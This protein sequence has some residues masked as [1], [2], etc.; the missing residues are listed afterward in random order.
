[1]DIMRTIYFSLNTLFDVAQIRTFEDFYSNLDNQIARLIPHVSHQTNEFN[2]QNS[3]QAM[4]NLQTQIEDRLINFYQNL[5][6]REKIKVVFS[7]PH[8]QN[9]SFVQAVNS[10]VEHLGDLSVNQSVTQSVCQPVNQSVNWSVCQSVCQSVSHN[11]SLGQKSPN[12]DFAH[13]RTSSPKTKGHSVPNFRPWLDRETQN[14]G[15]K[16]ILVDNLL[17]ANKPSNSDNP[18][19]KIRA[20]YSVFL[21]RKSELEA[22][23]SELLGLAIDEKVQPSTL[24]LRALDLKSRLTSLGIDSWINDDKICHIDPI[25]LSNWEDNISRNI[26]N[27]LYQTEDKINIRKGLAQ[28]G[29]KKGILPASVVQSLIFH[30]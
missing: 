12:N 11:N 8:L 3:I 23:V 27:V 26:A 5:S 10:P 29:L 16:K 30:C 22:E 18:N 14:Q 13:I 15:E 28:S 25:E 6:E 7:L 4:R 2:V 24:K 17:E 9:R 19:S 20:K 1:M 21:K